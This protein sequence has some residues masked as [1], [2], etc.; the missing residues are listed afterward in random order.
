MAEE[1]PFIQIFA[2]FRQ[3][4]PPTH[5]PAHFNLFIRLHLVSIGGSL[6]MVEFQS[7]H[8]IPRLDP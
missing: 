6:V 5:Q 4:W 8:T 1:R 3:L 2:L 7:G